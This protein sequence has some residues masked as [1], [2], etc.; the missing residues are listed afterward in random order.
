MKIERDN[1]FSGYRYNFGDLHQ[2]QVDGLTSLLDNLEAD[3]EITD[4]RCVAY[5][6]AAGLRLFEY[7]KRNRLPGMSGDD[8]DTKP[9]E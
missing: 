7:L 5:M 1:F 9:E 4:L 3:A 8:E 6:L 2:P